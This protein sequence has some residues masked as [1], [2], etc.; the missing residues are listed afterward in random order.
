MGT[1]IMTSKKEMIVP[2]PQTSPTSLIGFME[3][4]KNDE[5]PTA[6]VI[7]VKKQGQID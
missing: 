3:T 5:N 7:A 4:I 1:M 2:A 6:V